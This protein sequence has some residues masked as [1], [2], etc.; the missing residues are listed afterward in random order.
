MNEEF[1]DNGTEDER[2]ETIRA[3]MEEN[4]R[5]KAEAEKY[6]EKAMTLARANLENAKKYDEKLRAAENHN[7]ELLERYEQIAK[8]F[9]DTY[10]EKNESEEWTDYDTFCMLNGFEY[11][12]LLSM[13]HHDNSIDDEK[14]DEFVDKYHFEGGKAC[15]YDA[16]AYMLE[17]GLVEEYGAEL[18]R[19]T[20]LGK[21][22][23][24][25]IDNNT[26]SEDSEV[27]KNEKFKE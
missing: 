25:E 6:R 14:I 5:L 16:F 12:A 10:E 15:F 26:F 3:L 27:V 24:A 11:R 1:H 8:W 19:L 17:T 22:M 4:K 23:Y 2:I 9:I 18:Y 21:I 13:V 20:S 7:T